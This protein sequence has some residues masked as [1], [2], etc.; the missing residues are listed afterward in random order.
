MLTDMQIPI[1]PVSDGTTQRLI[2]NIQENTVANKDY[3]IDDQFILNGVL[4]KVTKTGSP[5]IAQGATIDI[6]ND[7]VVS[8]TITQQMKPKKLAEITATTS[9]TFKQALDALGSS[10]DTTLLNNLDAA[11]ITR[12]VLV[13]GSYCFRFTQYTSLGLVFEMYVIGNFLNM[14]YWAIGFSSNSSAKVY[15]TSSSSVVD[16]SPTNISFTFTP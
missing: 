11:T 8:D 4:Y 7:C 14:R 1:I 10:I 16:E 15:A 13:V 9:M 3:Y 6:A 12:L 2:A 5:A